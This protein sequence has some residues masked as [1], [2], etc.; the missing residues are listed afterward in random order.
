M[1]KAM[2][3]ENRLI[4]KEKSDADK[5]DRAVQQ[6]LERANIEAA[7][8]DPFLNEHFDKTQ[9]SIAAHRFVPANFKGL[10]EDQIK[11]I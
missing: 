8:N 5:R 9:S 1:K 4:A 7:E 11:S 10:R 3:E 2:M 6:K